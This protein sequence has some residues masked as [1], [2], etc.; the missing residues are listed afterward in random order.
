MATLNEIETSSIDDECFHSNAAKSRR[1]RNAI[2]FSPV[3]ARNESVGSAECEVIDDKIIEKNL[4]D[5]SMT[6]NVEKELPV[7]ENSTVIKEADAGK[8]DNSCSVANN[9]SH[10]VSSEMSNLCQDDAVESLTRYEDDSDKDSSGSPVL[11]EKQ[12]FW[13]KHRKSRQ[14][15]FTT[16]IFSTD[17]SLYYTFTK[18]C[19]CLSNF[20]VEPSIPIQAPT[21]K[22]KQFLV[23]L[24]IRNFICIYFVHVQNIKVG[25]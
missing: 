14:P 12:Y 23:S 16:D 20:S 21:E 25:D 3:D 19:H 7:I 17:M 18:S 13:K 1:R 4:N 9:S 15:S 10:A 2:D 22:G 24:L 6:T 11:D 5:S 8:L